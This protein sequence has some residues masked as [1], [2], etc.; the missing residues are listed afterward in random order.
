MTENILNKL[1]IDLIEARRLA[2][3]YPGR[4]IENIAANIEARVKAIEKQLKTTQQ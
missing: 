3:S 4:T 1:R 2:E